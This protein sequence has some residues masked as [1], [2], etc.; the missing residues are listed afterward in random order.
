MNL[1]SAGR[2]LLR[3]KARQDPRAYRY[4]HRTTRSRVPVLSS[5]S[6]ILLGAAELTR[7]RCEWDSDR[8]LPHFTVGRA[9]ARPEPKDPPC[10]A[11]RALPKPTPSRYLHE[12]VPTRS[13]TEVKRPVGR[14]ILA[15][16]EEPP[17]GKYAGRHVPAWACVHGRNTRRRRGEARRDRGY[18]QVASACRAWRSVA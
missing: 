18:A 15:M 11:P 14:Y 12:S 13:F 5:Y 6:T 9:N 1:R 10:L 2:Y 4:P 16:G 7:K 17:R 3:C 8:S